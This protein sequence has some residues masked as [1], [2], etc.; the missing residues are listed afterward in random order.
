MGIGQRQLSVVGEQLCSRTEMP[1]VD[2]GC[3]A[4]HQVA[5]SSPVGGVQHQATKRSRWAQADNSSLAWSRSVIDGMA[6]TSRSAP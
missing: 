1:I 5:E 6:S 3:V 4:V 2:E